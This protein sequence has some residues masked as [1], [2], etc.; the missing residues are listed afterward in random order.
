MIPILGFILLCLGALGV[1]S[2]YFYAAQRDK[3]QQRLAKVSMAASMPRRS[4]NR[5]RWASDQKRRTKLAM[6]GYSA[7]YSETVFMLLR[8]S[9]MIIAGG[10]WM[11]AQQL[12]L[13]GVGL[14]QGVAM[15]IVCGIVIDR[16]LDWRVDVVRQ[17]IARNTPDALDL[18]VVCVNSGLPLEETFRTVGEEMRTISPALA[19]EW[20]YTATEISV[21]DSPYRALDNLDERIALPEV[22]NMVV[23][24]SQALK[25]GTPMSEALKLIA[26]DSRQYHLLELEEWVGKI[27]AKMSFPLVVFIMLPVVV[28]IVAPVVLSLFNTLGQL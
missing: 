13:N 10:A 14:A 21:L 4:A 26:S 17:E 28:I 27:P 1:V 6:L 8:I 3:V 18:M 24:M 7:S 11:M 20:L 16:A 12:E 19:R 2:S 23:T 25:F 15:A 9:L 5:W 22:N